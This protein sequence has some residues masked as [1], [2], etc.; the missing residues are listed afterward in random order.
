MN[1]PTSHATPIS[2]LSHDMYKQHSLTYIYT[3]RRRGRRRSIIFLFMNFSFPRFSVI[4]I[5][6]FC[7]VAW[8]VL[9]LSLFLFKMFRI[10]GLGD[11][12]DYLL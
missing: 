6:I 1:V 7:M 12:G 10:T 11:F 3:R 2:T 8:P 9:F 4:C 5:G